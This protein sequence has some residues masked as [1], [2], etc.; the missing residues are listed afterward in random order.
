MSKRFI[1]V[2]SA[3]AAIAAFALGVHAE[4][5]G[6]L[7][8][9]VENDA[10]AVLTGLQVASAAGGDWKTVELDQ[11]RVKRG[12]SAGGH[13]N[14]AGRECLFNIRAEF[15]GRPATEQDGVDLCDLDANTLIIH[16]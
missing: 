10:G 12:E 15:A 4:T 5:G 11:A 8:F 7:K 3:F 9:G 13:L 6:R 2:A 1:V 14:G 16:D